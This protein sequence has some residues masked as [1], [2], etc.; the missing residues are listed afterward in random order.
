MAECNSGETVATLRNI[1][2]SLLV[3]RTFIFPKFTGLYNNRSGGDSRWL[4]RPSR[5]PWE[6]PRQRKTVEK[7]KVLNKGNSH[8]RVT[9]LSASTSTPCRDSI[10]ISG[11][12]TV[13]VVVNR[14]SSRSPALRWT[15]TSRPGSTGCPCVSL[16]TDGRRRQR[17]P[18]S[19]KR[20]RGPSRSRRDAAALNSSRRVISGRAVKWN[21]VDEEIERPGDWNN[22]S[23][24]VKCYRDT[25]QR[26]DI[27]SRL[28]HFSGA[29]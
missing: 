10:I 21:N 6:S 29:G 12:L 11:V 25:T 20:E 9:D 26:R 7:R 22:H 4:P 8:C 13:A 28:G 19:T 16:E 15:H 5:G 27:R 24:R 2:R 23:R 3:L 1:I 14:S 18:R 17:E